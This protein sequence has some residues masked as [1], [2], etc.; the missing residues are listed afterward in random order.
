MAVLLT[1]FAVF[2]GWTALIWTLR[3]RQRRSGLADSPTA[4]IPPGSPTTVIR[5]GAVVGRISATWPLAV[6]SFDESSAELRFPLLRPV[7][8]Q[9]DEVIRITRGRSQRL[10]FETASGRLDHVT[11]AGR[12]ASAALLAR[13]WPVSESR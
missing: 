1:I 12:G 4:A 9:R 3:R 8:I 10:R 6:L 11:F 7:H 13:G 2:G 5:G